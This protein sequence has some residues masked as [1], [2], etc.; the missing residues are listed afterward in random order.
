MKEQLTSV[1]EYLTD[2]YVAGGAITSLH[3]GNP[4]NDYDIYPKSQ[5]GLIN[6]LTW[7]FESGFNTFV[8]DRA[9]T[10]SLKNTMNKTTG[11]PATMQIMHFDTFETAEKIFDYFDFTCCMGAFDLDTKEFVLHDKFLLHC[12]QRYLSFNDKTKFPYASARRIQK[13]LDRGFKINNTEYMK[14]LMACQNKPIN[15]WKELKEQI[16][17]IYGECMVIPENEPYSYEAAIKTIENVEFKTEMKCFES[18]EEAI[19]SLVDMELEYLENNSCSDKLYTNSYKKYYIKIDGKFIPSKFKPKNG[20]LIT[21]KDLFPD[22]LLYKVVL[23]NDDGIYRSFYKKD[24]IYKIGDVVTSSAPGIFALPKED[25][26]SKYKNDYRKDKT[27]LELRIL[28]YNDIKYN[29]REI[30]LSK[31]YVVR[32]CDIKEFIST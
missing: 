20:K 18:S 25:I 32:E 15:S 19:A 29:L 10:Y 28:D 27:I 2:C 6:A 13:Y 4:I 23:K 3:T 8:S 22:G 26:A 9:I 30:T 17:G 31:C 11:L 24:F 21:Y 16:G 12:S 5:Q 14:I 1:L 7:G